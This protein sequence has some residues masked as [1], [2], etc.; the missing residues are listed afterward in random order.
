MLISIGRLYIRSKRKERAKGGMIT[1]M[2]K[3]KGKGKKDITNKIIEGYIETKIEK[4]RENI[5]IYSMYNQGNLEGR[6]ENI[7]NIKE[8]KDEIVIV[9]GDFNIRT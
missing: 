2:R 1:G 6:I 3:A 8:G 4:D 7:R 9:G 5:K